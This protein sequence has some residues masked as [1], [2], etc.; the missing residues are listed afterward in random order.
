[1]TRVYRF[2]TDVERDFL[3]KNY[4]EKGPKE[5]ARLLGRPVFSIHD[6][7]R[8]LELAD[9]GRQRRWRSKINPPEKDVDASLKYGKSVFRVYLVGNQKFALVEQRDLRKVLK[10]RWRAFISCKQWYA[11][12]SVKRDVLYMHD[13]IINPKNGLE[14]DHRNWNGLDN[15]RANLR[16]CSSSEN[17]CN[18]GAQSNN[19]SGYKGVSFVKTNG[20]W[21]CRIM[22]NNRNICLGK[23]DTAVE[24]ARAYNKAALKYHGEFAFL[25]KVD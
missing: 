10:H 9:S 17:K 7:A 2:W 3:R 5:C 25:N 24:A 13:L 11:Y 15:V 19:T 12:T 21:D 20:K 1:M 8:K 22:K 6:V 16:E 23:F 18:R 4:L 14:V